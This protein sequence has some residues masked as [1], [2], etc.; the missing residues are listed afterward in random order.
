MGYYIIIRGPLGCGKT[1]T[2]KALSARLSAEYLSVDEVINEYKLDS[3]KEDGFISQA[4]FKKANDHLAEKAKEFLDKKIPVIIDGNFYW[5]S[6]IEDLASKLVYPY[7]IFTLDAPLPVCVN[8]DSKR[9]NP[10]GADAVKVVYEK[11][12]SVEAGKKIDVTRET[13]AIITEIIDVLIM[14]NR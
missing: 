13:E 6:Q 5:K 12:A 9:E 2:A 4:S 3:D 8:R 1:T 11:T 7:A 14:K 10:L